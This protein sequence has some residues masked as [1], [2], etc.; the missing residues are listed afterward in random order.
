MSKKQIKCMCTA[1][2]DGFQSVYGARVLTKD[3]LP[4]LEA[5]KEAGI[6]HFE[7]GGG[8]R[9]QSLYF[10]CNEDAFDM[11]DAFRE[12]VGPEVNL[13]TLARGVNV[14]GLD[15]QPSDIIDLH[16]K[17]F[18]KHGVTTI[19]NFDALNDVNN[20]DYSGNAI[21]N[22]G[23]R[24]QI[25]ITLMELPPGLTGAH[26]AEYYAGVLKDILAADIP[27]DSLCLKD[28][29]GT[30]TPAK[31]YDTVREVRKLLP[32]DVP[33]HYHTHE[34]A[35]VS[36][37]A[38]KAAIDAGAEML[39]LSL[40]PV[41]GGT[42][43]PDILTMAHALKG[44]D[45]E[46]DVDVDK[47]LVAE[48]VFRDCMKDYFLPPEAKSVDPVIPWSP[49][50]GGALTANTQMLRDNNMMD[51]FPDII[52]NMQEVVRKGGFGTSVTPVSQFYFQQA[53][54]NTLFG[55]W[56]KIADGYG[57]MV[58]G[59]FGKTPYAP[60]ETVLAKAAEQL[61]L[62][63]TTKTVREL[64]DADEDKGIAPAT[65]ALKEA[66]LP[67]T[68]ENI[69]IVATCKEKGITFLK[70]EA[71]VSVRKNA[72]ESTSGG[73]SSSG[74]YTV[75][76]GG[77]PYEVVLG[78]DGSATVNGKSYST[79]VRQGI[80]E[81]TGGGASSSA[82]GEEVFAPMPG[83]VFKIQVQEGDSVAEGDV[84]YILEA[85]KMENDVR[86]SVS[87]TVT[88]LNFDIGEQVNDGDVLAV[89]S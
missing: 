23:L 32:A 61:G 54:N 44:T 34:T 20:L 14:V 1:F 49:M 62:E 74:E 40:D 80:S 68:D 65:A 10:Y 76:V 45:Y 6:T 2:R 66:G 79:E 17:L 36:I 13:Q 72:S 69:F 64:N 71:E 86:A 67:I 35:G 60:D 31:V 77:K 55:D 39:D 7:S 4:A 37:L 33:I 70:G 16:A 47:I 29:S 24:H 43:Q 59:Y 38:Y 88:A 83:K 57:R 50:P 75:V 3:F 30:L 48:E 41:S 27:F 5:A 21:V 22:A 82:E 87:G 15:S 58:L 73:A 63:P 52:K 42:C 9:F 26:T 8:A 53:L 56:E 85:M 78:A 12:T 19:R 51:R 25:A 46:L 11:M 89:I 84:L 18:K 81:K 28:A